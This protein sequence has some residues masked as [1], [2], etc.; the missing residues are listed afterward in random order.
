MVHVVAPSEA[1]GWPQRLHRNV[2]HNMCGLDFGEPVRAPV[3]YP[4]TGISLGDAGRVY[5]F[6]SR[7]VL[8]RLS[9]GGRRSGGDSSR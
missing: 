6:A 9:P 1:Q 3:N 7:H 2:G 4:S 8:M 5:F